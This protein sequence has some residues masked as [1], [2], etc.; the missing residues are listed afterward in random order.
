MTTREWARI[1]LAFVVTLTGMLLVGGWYSATSWCWPLYVLVG[2]AAGA[3]AG[4][5]RDIWVVWV[6]AILLYPIAAWLDLPRMPVETWINWFA[7]TVVGACLVTAGFAIGALAVDRLVAARLRGPARSAGRA[8]GWPLVIGALAIGLV[9]IGGWTGYAAVVGSE[10]LVH[11]DVRWPD[12]GTP[13]SEYGWGYEAINYDQADDARLEASYPGMKACEDFGTPAGDEVMASDGVHV[14]GWYIPA[15]NRVGPAGPTLVIV[16]GWQSH[17]S[18]V[19]KYA[20][21]FH[22][23]YNLVLVDLRRQGRSGGTDTTWGLGEQLDVRAMI[24]WLERTKHPAW[25]AAMGNSMGAATALLEAAGDPRVEA[26]ILDS[27]HASIIASFTDGLENEQHLP[28]VPTAWAMVVGGSQQVDADLTSADPVRNIGRVGDR[29]VLLLHSRVDVLDV[30]EHSADR[31][32][33][34]ARAAGVP[35]ELHYCEAPVIGSDPGHGHGH[36]INDCP[37]AWAAWATEFLAAAMAD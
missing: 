36:V 27:M 1:A 30:P 10:R 15:A 6:A 22:E 9:G 17:K 18:E 20:P 37:E 11:S 14:A 28:G 35:V 21:P 29:P 8:V 7:L 24:D 26:L 33:E 12:C 13:A 4:R 34:A 31:N 3:M 25:I 5:G 2:I 19:L 32:F 16:P 23:A